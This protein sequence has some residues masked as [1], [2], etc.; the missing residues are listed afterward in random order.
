MRAAALLH[1][2]DG[3]ILDM[4]SGVENCEAYR[5][6]APLLQSRPCPSAHACPALPDMLDW[7]DTVHSLDLPGGAG[8]CL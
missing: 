1:L 4:L 5:R 8:E 2:T 7:H 6:A 3:Q